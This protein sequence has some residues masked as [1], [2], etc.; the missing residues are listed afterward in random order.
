M[1]NTPPFLLL[2]SPYLSIEALPSHPSNSGRNAKSSA[3]I[4]THGRI[5]VI[6]RI[7]NTPLQLSIG[8]GN[9]GNPSAKYGAHTNASTRLAVGN[10]YAYESDGAALRLALAFGGCCCESGGGG[11]QEDEG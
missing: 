11:G 9:P 6:A 2:F 3:I 7:V 8:A 5:T 1:V 4:T 10:R